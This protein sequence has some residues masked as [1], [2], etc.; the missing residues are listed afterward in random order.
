MRDH[1]RPALALDQVGDAQVLLLEQTLGVH[2]QHHDLGETD[3]VDAC[4]RPNSFSS[5]S[6]MRG[7]RRSP[8]VSCR[9]KVRPF[10]FRSTAMVSRVIPASGPVSR[11][12]SPSS[13]FTSVDLPEFG[14]PTTATR[15]GRTASLDILRSIG[16][17]FSGDVRQGFAQ[18]LEQIDQPLA[19][20]GRDADRIAETELVGLQ[21]PGAAALALGLVGD[22]DH[23]L[24]GA[25]H[26]IGKGAVVRHRSGF[27][28]EHEEHRVGLLDRQLGL[29]QHPAGEALGVGLFKPGGIDDG[30]VQIAEPGLTLAPVAGD[31]GQVVDQRQAPADQPVEQ[32]G[33]A[34]VRPPDDRDGE[35]HGHWMPSFRRA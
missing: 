8:A 14:R 29:R 10:Q 27:R 20:L 18:R 5:F 28:I 15:I 13:R 23:R 25:P 22:D 11:R 16:V 26:Q 24:A 7:G 4:R 32:R 2:Q 19:V 34:D 17:R 1:Q 30:E 31:A 21:H 6:W 33:L 12:S 35:A 9:R 3:G